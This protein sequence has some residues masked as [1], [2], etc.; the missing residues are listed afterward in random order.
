MHPPEGLLCVPSWD[1]LE[2]SDS[3]TRR[4]PGGPALLTRNCPGPGAE[5]GSEVAPVGLT[6]AQA[7]VAQL[8]QQPQRI[9]QEL[10]CM[11]LALAIYWQSSTKITW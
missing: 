11:T 7:A 8:A 9:F 6:Q 3:S 1:D 5:S 10:K 4:S 2:S